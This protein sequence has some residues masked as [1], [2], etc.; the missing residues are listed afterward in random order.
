[1]HIKKTKFIILRN[2]NLNNKFT[3]AEIL[4]KIELNEIK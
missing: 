1:M 3:T 2:Q 4:N